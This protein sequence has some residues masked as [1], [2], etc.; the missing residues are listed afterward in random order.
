[1]LDDAQVQPVVH[2]LNLMAAKLDY[3]GFSQKHRES[4]DATETYSFADASRAAKWPPLSGKFTTYG[5]TLPL[6]DQWDDHMVVMGSGDE[7]KLRFSVPDQPLQR[8]GN[9]ILCST[10]FGWDKDADLNTLVGQSSE[11]LPFKQM[12]VIHRRLRINHA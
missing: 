4:A 8:V 1:M 7:L 3:H 12:Q 2:D 6:L 9:G 11:P 5:D 10:V